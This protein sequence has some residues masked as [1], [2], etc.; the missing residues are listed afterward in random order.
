[1]E[2]AYGHH[3]TSEDDPFLRMAEKI[4]ELTAGVGPQGSN[5]VDLFPIRESSRL[6]YS[7]WEA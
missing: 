7:G 4:N 5:I 2:I 3:I 6:R 1:M